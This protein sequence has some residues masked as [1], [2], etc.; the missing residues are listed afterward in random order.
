MYVSVFMSIYLSVQAYFCVQIFCVHVCVCACKSA[1][2][3]V[4]VCG[5]QV[6]KSKLRRGSIL[7]SIVESY[8]G[9]GVAVR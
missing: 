6:E 7:Q 2:V 1:C 8:E 9:C 5:P 4:C 3:C